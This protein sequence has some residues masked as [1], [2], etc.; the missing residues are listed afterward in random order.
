MN[1]NKLKT[2][3]QA[4]LDSAIGYIESET[5]TERRKSL[6]A[7]LRRPYGTEVEG[8]ST[9]VTGEVA[10][11]VDGAMPHLMRIFAS[12]ENAV[13]FEA[14]NP[15]GVQIAEQITDYCN[16]VFYTQN[17]G[18]DILH[19]TMKTALTQKVGIFKAYY[20]EKEHANTETY[21][22]LTEEEMTMLLAD[23]TR[24][25]VSQEI[26]EEIIQ[27]E[28]GEAITKRNF[29]VEVRK[30]TSTGKIV[31]ESL[32]PEEFLISKKGKTIADS[33]FC[34]HR[35]L[36][37]RTDLV[38]LGFDPE[39]VETL[40]AYDELSY[41]PERVSRFSEGEQPNDME[42][43]DKS[44]E[45]IEVFECYL[46][47]DF[48]DD[49][50]AERR[51]VVYSGNEVLSNEE[52]DFNP[53][54]A[55]C[56]YPLPHKF[57]GQSLADRSMDIQEQKTAITRA[58]LDSLYLSLA[59]RVGVVEG[60]ANL[61]DLLNVTAGGVVRLKNPNAIVPMTVP[62]LANQ[63]FPMLEYLDAVQ[64]KRTGISDAMQGLAPDVLQN[65]TAAAIAASTNAA[66]GKIELIA[67]IFAETG[68]KSLF[69]G[70]LH[71][72]CKYDSKPQII[73]MRGKYINVDPSLWDTQYDVLVNVGLGT[74][75]QKQQMSILQMVMQKQ[76][77]I[78]KMFGPNNPL[79]SVGQYR[80]T[81]AKFIETS[82]FKDTKQFFRE[83]TPEQD[84][85]LAQQGQQKKQDP[86]VSAAMAQ[87]QAQI[88]IDK[89]KAEAD[90]AI[91]QRKM[92][93]D[94]QL[95]REKMMQELELKKQEFLAEAQIKATKVSN[96]MTGN[97][98]IPN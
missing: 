24:E 8:R 55:I 97:T 35:K 78:L 88:A 39:V 75:D 25:V 3:V 34:A 27:N 18:F 36:I 21:E 57:F 84:Q 9:I 67:R 72:A 83:I 1:E 95:Q 96:D 10:E 32:P 74:G 41:T 93:A 42:S 65:V 62:Q 56:P 59:P 11:A 58:I 43:L 45:E 13:K 98:E 85:M 81:L 47:T 52:I 4:E 7:Y 6:E 33:P 20:E 79:V 5:T 19:E 73:R 17:E 49:G 90:I 31:V 66:T 16:W 26:T 60:Q 64:G 46:F 89:Q 94:I 29:A 70:I 68:I 22:S 61:D 38:A 69:K 91:K 28:L 71:L 40:P 54:H 77:E 15:Q 76:E 82:G 30:K 80:E 63:A 86:V 51:K 23:E 2:I 53:F 48:N 50:I 14:R 12:S 37:T 87:A 92:E 44:M